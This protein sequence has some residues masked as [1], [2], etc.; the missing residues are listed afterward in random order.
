MLLLVGAECFSQKEKNNLDYQYALIE[1]VKQK[2]LGNLSEAVKLYRLVVREKPDCDVAYYELGGI[3]LMSKQVELATSNLKKAYELIPENKWYTMAYLNALG[4]GEAYDTMEDLLK[5]KIKSEPGEVEWEYQL[6][7]V[8]FSQEKSKKALKTLEHIEKER[9]F[10][11]KVTL[12]KASIYEKDEQ[13]DLARSEIEKVMVLFPEALQFRIVAA[14]LCL[15][16]GEEEQAAAYYM[17]IL[18]VDSTNIFALTNLTDYYRKIEDYKNSFKYL[19]KS[20]NNQFVEARRKLA[21]LSYYLSEEKFILNFGEELGNLIEV[22]LKVHPEEADVHLMASDFYINRKEYAEAFTHLNRYLGEKGGGY[23][24]YMQA[25]LLA[26]A[27]SLNNELLHVTGVA[28]ALFP[29]SADIRFFRGI[30]FYET[31]MYENLISCLDSVGFDRFSERAYAEQSKMLYAEAYYRLGDFGKSDS[32]FASIIDD[33]PDNYLVL[34]N[35]SYYLAERG[36]KLEQAKAW[37]LEAVQN[38]PE[39]STFLDTYAWILYKMR[40]F[41]EAEQYILRAIDK[42]GQNDPEINEHAGDI[43]AALESVVIA[44]SYYMKAIILGGDKEKLEEKI[45]ALQGSE[46]E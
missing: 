29:D 1:A 10:S 25:I 37:S 7:T 36:E 32:V 43:Q 9:G 24:L 12:L 6:A 45:N 33:D 40:R 23:P 5:W 46:C 21:I 19:A 38:N 13:Y 27:G 4:A 20:F 41:E 31:G 17:Q 22:L 30:G 16:S 15:K 42:G 34:N 35:Y 28:S 39:N 11:E 18:E 14:E 8:Y 3:F 2:N 26:N 44:R